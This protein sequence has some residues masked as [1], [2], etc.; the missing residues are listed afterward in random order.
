MGRLFTLIARSPA[1]S[2]WQI[3][4]RIGD[5]MSRSEILRSIEVEL[6]TVRD[7]AERANQSILVY[8]VD[9]AI[10]EVRSKIPTNKGERDGSNP[11]IQF[12]KRYSSG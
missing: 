1:S 8:L 11:P 5:L 2:L 10:L 7:M 12:S 4:G 6:G 3:D 9:M